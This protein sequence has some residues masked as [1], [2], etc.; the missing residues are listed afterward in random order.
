ME[1]LPSFLADLQHL[2]LIGYWLVFLISLAESLVFTGTF[3]P[4]TIVIVLM[5]GFAVHGYYHFWLLC[6]FSSVGAIFGDGISYEIGRR[7]QMHLE[8]W[9]FLKK[10]IDRARPF[11]QRHQRK[12]IFLGRFIG[13]TRPIMPFLAGVAGM[14][15]TLFYSMDSISATAWSVFYIGIGYVFGA[16]WRVALLLS[17]RLLLL[18]VLGFA[19]VSVFL[20]LWRW[21]IINGKIVLNDTLQCIRP[22]T[23]AVGK[24]YPTFGSAVAQRFATRKFNGL[25]LTFLVGVM[26]VI[27]AIFL[28]ITEDFLHGDQLTLIDVR[29][30]NL[31]L[32]FRTGLLLKIFY[33]ITMLGEWSIVIVLSLLLSLFFLHH[34]LRSF[35]IT[36]WVALLSS[37]IITLICKIVFHRLRPSGLLPAIEEHGYSFPSAHATIVVSFYGFLAYVIIRTQSSWRSRVSA[38]FMALSIIVLVDFSRLYLG[39]HYVSD[40]LAG[41]LVGFMSL[42]FA[43]SIGEWLREQSRLVPAYGKN[44]WGLVITTIL[45]EVLFLILFLTVFPVH[46]NGVVATAENQMTETKA[47]P[48]LF[49][50]GVLPEFTETLL[51]R[52]RQPVNILIVANEQCLLH[53]FEDARWNRADSISFPSLLKIS[54]AAFLSEEFPPSAPVS[55]VFYR[56]FPQDFS[57][58]YASISGSPRSRHHVRLWNTGFA[59]PEGVLFAGTASLDTRLTWGLRHA[60]S[61]NVDDERK[62]ISLDLRKSG[63]TQSITLLGHVALIQLRPCTKL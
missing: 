48:H 49:T 17:S 58:E 38:F 50:D 22:I 26:L 29:F 51:G 6:L 33:F 60:M 45:A 19:T 5:G 44:L 28:G 35:V 11:F 4:G 2:G 3:I 62:K 47:I 16:A 52:K 32:A 41:N 37:G 55:P 7:G 13:P 42:L 25:P 23:D 53:A 43:I 39:V 31:L 54:I 57:F 20:L 63:D 59:T 40:V 15:R 61:P 18:C 24:R 9:S 36:L 21:A 27:I 14:S 12:S 8:R 1:S 46:F 30:E 56:S 34:R 10:H